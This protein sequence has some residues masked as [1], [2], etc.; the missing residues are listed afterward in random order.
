MIKID[1]SI[2]DDMSNTHIIRVVSPKRN[3]YTLYVDE[4]VFAEFKANRFFN[5]EYCF[6]VFGKKCSIVKVLTSSSP[7]LVV[8]GVY[9]ENTNKK[10]TPIPKPT[11][12]TY[13]N[14]I[15]NALACIASVLY[16]VIKKGYDNLHYCILLICF[17]F[18]LNL[19]IEYF[20]TAPLIIKNSK[21]RF[22]YRII[23][24]VAITVCNSI[25]LLEFL[26]K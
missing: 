16:M 3:V 21:I 11:W 22:V 7:S 9:Q 24:T 4:V 19:M 10:Y 20:S 13:L 6:E 17:S 14:L 26:K 12:F 5:D 23:L 1:W 2:K 15:F 18:S 25:V 8:D